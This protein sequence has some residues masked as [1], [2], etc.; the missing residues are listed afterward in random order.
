MA[1]SQDF[2]AMMKDM[3]GAFP[4]D[5]KA[6]QGMFQNQAELSEKLA[7]VALE[8]AEKSADISN[9]WAKETLSNLADVTTTKDDA[10]AYAKALT[11]F[12]SAHAEVASENMAAFAEVAKQAQADTVELLMAAGKDLQDDTASAMK[13]AS[14]EAASAARKATGNK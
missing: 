4:V 8:A 5:G 2:S 1:Q 9:K 7:K 3:M 14:N 6:F 11:D 13:S 10:S 12:A